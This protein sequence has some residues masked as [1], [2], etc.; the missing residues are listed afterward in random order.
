MKEGRQSTSTGMI[1][2]DVMIRECSIRIVR[3]NREWTMNIHNP[4]NLSIE[5]LINY[6]ESNF[7]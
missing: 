6:L 4:W 3:S 1:N 7:N 2:R 5:F